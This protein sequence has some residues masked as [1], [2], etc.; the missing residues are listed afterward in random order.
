MS[1]LVLT[2]VFL[3]AAAA[4]AQE[5]PVKSDLPLTWPVT[6]KLASSSAGPSGWK[7]AVEVTIT[8]T[9]TRTLQLDGPSVAEGGEIDNALFEVTV[10]GK[11]VEYRGEMR[12]RAP[13]DRFV[14]VA[15]GKSYRVVV[16]LSEAWPVPPGPHV[17]TVRFS[18]RNHF[19]PD[20]F[21]LES[22]PLSLSL[23]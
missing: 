22:E 10:D 21:N 5:K 19:S 4:F 18:H 7:Y 12:K 11:K 15:A 1:R 17:V 20:G 16:E 3:A 13:P 23:R 14:K 9:L 6:L 2:F 8:N